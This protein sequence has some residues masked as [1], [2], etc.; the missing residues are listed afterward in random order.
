LGACKILA[1]AGLTALCTVA[2]GHAQTA[3]SSWAKFCGRGQDVRGQDVRDV[4]LTGKYGINDA[5]QPAVAAVLIEP[6]GDAG[7]VFRI[8]VPGPLLLEIQAINLAK[9]SVTFPLPLADSA[10]NSF[11]QANDGPPMDPRAFEEQQ[12]RLRGDLQG[13]TGVLGR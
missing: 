3:Y 7:K 2:A 6:R 8:T 4:C 10:G 9:P 5:G 12:R 11:R 13:H 1:V